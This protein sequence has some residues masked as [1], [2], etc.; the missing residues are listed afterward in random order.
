MTVESTPPGPETAASDPTVA[1]DAVHGVW[2]VGTLTIEP[3]G[4]ARLRRALDR[5]AALVAAGRRGVRPGARQGLD[6]VRQRRGEPVPRPLL[7]ASTPTTTKNITVSQ[8]SDDGGADVVGAGAG[9][10]DP[11]R[12]AAGRRCRTGRSSSSRATIAG[13]DGTDRLDRRAPLDR[14]RRDVHARRPSRPPAAPTTTPMRAISLPSRRHRLG[15]D[16]LRRRGTTAASAP[17]CAAN[18]MVLST[19]TDGA[20]VDARRRGS[21][22][23]RRR[24]RSARSSPASPPTRRIRGGS[25]L[26]YAYFTPGSCATR[27]VH[28]R[29]RLHAVADG[30]T[31]WTAPQRLDAQPMQTDVAAARRGRPHGRRLL[32]DVVRRRPRRAGVRARDVAARRAA[33]ARRSSR[34]RYRRARVARPRARAASRPRRRRSSHDARR[35]ERRLAAVDDRERAAG[36]ER[37]ERQPGDRVDLERRADD[38]Q[39]PRLRRELRSRARSPPRAAARRT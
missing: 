31:T 4:V 17:G 7:R 24:R 35:V 27:H 26:V 6:R 3:G 25:A 38:E 39:Q 37:L 10:G 8:S 19:S 2:L 11:R 5:R 30:G 33:S 23:R 16:D 20:D 9:G 28:A 13:E 15:R 18:D 22:S 21:R 36:G 1:Y 34:R 14:R 29:D 12:H 32:L